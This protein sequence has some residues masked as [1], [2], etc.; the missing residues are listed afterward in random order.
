MKR[1]CALYIPE[2]WLQWC[3]KR[4]TRTN[5]LAHPVVVV[6]EKGDDA[7]IVSLNKVAFKA[8][9]RKGM[10]LALAR[11][12]QGCADLEV[13]HCDKATR[14]E[15]GEQVAKALET[16]TP[17]VEIS[18]EY[19]GVF[20]VDPRG[21][22]DF[23]GSHRAWLEQI[24]MG[25]EYAL[26]LRHLRGV[27][28]WS[29][30][31][32]S[33]LARLSR[34]DIDLMTREDEQRQL[35]KVAL[36][37]AKWL[38]GKTLQGFHDV[39][40]ETVAD[41]LRLEEASVRE[42]LGEEA[43]TLHRAL[44]RMG[45]GQ[46]PLQPHRALAPISTRDEIAWQVERAE[47]CHRAIARV[48]ETLKQEASM[49]REEL[50]EVSIRLEDRDGQGV[51]LDARA[52]SATNTLSYWERVLM[53][54]LRNTRFIHKIEVIEAH[55]VTARRAAT[56]QLLAATTR[57]YD[58]GED[59]LSQLRATFGEHAVRVASVAPS[60][61]PEEQTSLRRPGKLR[62][63][64][65]KRRQDSRWRPW[66]RVVSARPSRTNTPPRAGADVHDVSDPWRGIWRRYHQERPVTGAAPRWLVEDRK[67]G[68]YW[69]LGFA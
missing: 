8:G 24:R 23:W 51:T 59:A 2:L 55:A 11:S 49:R 7:P 28:G 27:I 36:I 21:M 66:V 19:P 54:K 56:A 32:V 57:D 18:A 22:D 41:L 47:H 20:L 16:W 61:F 39:G 50:L 62:Q 12:S 5:P 40:V 35:A 52:S 58:A 53:E 15:V 63:P 3:V 34:E 6:L 30:E 25:V 9:L 1:W 60:P 17:W 42:R 26:G 45:A 44:S 4:S 29:R 46:K 37:R 65:P 68:V 67:H 31:G 48:L 64:A 69:H 13:L 38:S 10:S 43:A 33:I 14:R